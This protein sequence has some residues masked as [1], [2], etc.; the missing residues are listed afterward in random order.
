MSLFKGG[1]RAITGAIGKADKDAYKLKTP[2][3]TLGVRGTHYGVFYCA[4]NCGTDAQGKPNKPGLYGG[5]VDGAIVMTNDTGSKQ[6]DNDQYFHIGSKGTAPEFLLQPPGK[7]FGGIESAEQGE[8]TGDELPPPDGD[9]ALPPQDDGALP[10][11]PPPAQT[12]PAL[13]TATKQGGRFD[14]LYTGSGLALISTVKTQP[15]EGVIAVLKPS[16][17]VLGSIGSVTNIVAGVDS[18]NATDCSPCVFLPGMASLTEVSGDAM[19]GVNWGTWNGSSV[20]LENGSQVST[21]TYFSYIYSPNITA[22]L[23]TNGFGYYNVS[24]G[25]ALRDQN[26]VA[27]SLSG[28]IDVDFNTQLFT[29]GFLSANSGQNSWALGLPGPPQQ[30]PT[31]QPISV[32]GNGGILLSGICSG[33]TDPSASGLVKGAFVGPNAEGI[34]TTIELKSTTDT[35]TGVQLFT[36]SGGQ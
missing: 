35:V 32:L 18:N 12:D 2:V 31:P 4:A 27:Y 23:P 9:G 19:L 16:D 33:C 11:P 10:P 6:F 28:Y 24:G 14:S 36:D 21:N 13:P 5:V 29:D 15:R 22:S 25:P 1:M 8:N 26:G 20:L 17:F 34:I 30:P 3:A 7:V